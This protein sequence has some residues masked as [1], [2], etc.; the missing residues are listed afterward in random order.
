VKQVPGT[1]ASDAVHRSARGAAHALRIPSAAIR[2]LYSVSSEQIQGVGRDADY[3]AGKIAAGRKVRRAGRSVGD[4]S[5]E[6]NVM[7]GSGGASRGVR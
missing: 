1:P 5:G 3:I 6:R 4:T 2:F 7:A